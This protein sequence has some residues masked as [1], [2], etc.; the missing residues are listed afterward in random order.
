V[1]IV[2]EYNAWVVLKDKWPLAL[3]VFA[4]ILTIFIVRTLGARAEK[5][6]KAQD[7]E[8]PQ[9]VTGQ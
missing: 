1:S 9:Q 4:V 2:G 7:S 5:K 3:V 8:K 6:K